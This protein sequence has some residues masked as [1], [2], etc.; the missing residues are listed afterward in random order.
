MLVSGWRIA[1]SKA[2][3]ASAPFTRRG[4]RGASWIIRAKEAK[5]SLKTTLQTRL[6]D[7][8]L[9]FLGK[10]WKELNRVNDGLP[11][12]EERLRI[13]LGVIHQITV[14]LSRVYDPDRDRGFTYQP[15]VLQEFQQ[16]QAGSTYPLWKRLKILEGFYKEVEDRRKEL[17][18][19]IQSVRHEVDSQ[20][21]DL[22]DGKKALPTQAITMPLDLFDSEL[23]FAADHPNRTI[24]VGGS[25]L[26][27]KSLGFKLHG[28]N[29]VEAR[30]RLGEI[31]A[32]LRAQPGRIVSQF[33]ECMGLWKNLRDGKP[34]MSESR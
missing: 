10:T 23:N 7:L 32:E 16:L 28:R 34:T 4:R 20:V 14:V 8:S 15:E 25:T 12:F 33:L 18:K 26:G 21:P 5:H 2:R 3:I 9:D 13:A 29:Y 31:E 6:E 17:L 22:S 19:R 30:D 1:S 11:V 27:I 24:T